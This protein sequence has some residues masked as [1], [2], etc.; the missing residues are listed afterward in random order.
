MAGMASVLFSGTL[1]G[2]DD[3]ASNDPTAVDSSSDVGG[4]VPVGPSQAQFGPSPA[5]V[6][7]AQAQMAAATTTPIGASAS[8]ESSISKG[9]GSLISGLAPVVAAAAA[10]EAK[11]QYNQ[12]TV[13]GVTTVNT[14]SALNTLYSFFASP[15]FITLVI[16]TGV[17]IGGLLLFRAAEK[18]A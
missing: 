2:E 16:G 3:D 11:V 14:S 5:E 6:M 12:K 4:G 7:A 8:S 18:G 15:A 10:N 9:I 17:V 1:D 13:G